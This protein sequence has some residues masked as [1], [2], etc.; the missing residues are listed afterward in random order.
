MKWLYWLHQGGLRFS[1]V[2]TLG[3]LNFYAGANE[4]E[5][6]CE[7]F[8]FDR[9]LLDQWLT[10]RPK[11]S[12]PFFRMLGASTVDSVDNSAYEGATIV[13]D[14][15]EP[16]PSALDGAFDLVYD[17]GTLEHVFNF[18]EA[19]RSAMRM[20]S[21]G[22]SLISNQCFNNMAGHGF[23]CFGPEVFFRTLCNDNGFD[24]K[25]IRIYERYPRSPWY[26]LADPRDSGQRIRLISW[27]LEV[28]VLVHAVKTAAKPVFQ[29]WPQQ[30]DYSSAWVEGDPR[31]VTTRPEAEEIGIDGGGALGGIKALVLRFLRE[32]ALRSPRRGRVGKYWLNARNYSLHSQRDRLTLDDPFYQGSRPAIYPAP[33]VAQRTA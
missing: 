25:N 11:Y 31:S 5:E 21:V 24:L 1:K 17:G 23:Y 33:E 18:P 20:V 14:L 10:P 19:L 3:R 32:K 13:H 22:G 26:R 27:G 12:D 2:V 6:L 28:E 30:S 16:I 7:A 8:R 15:N 29:R 9:D 4:A